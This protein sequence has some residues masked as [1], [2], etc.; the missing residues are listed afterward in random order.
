MERSADAHALVQFENLT[1]QRNVA[2]RKNP[3][4]EI[5]GRPSPSDTESSANSEYKD[6]PPRQSSSTSSSSSDPST[7]AEPNKL[8]FPNGSR[9]PWPENNDVD[10]HKNLP[11]EE[12]D[13]LNN[14]DYDYFHEDD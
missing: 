5:P 10:G 11:D 6:T 14:F 4:N 2:S 3:I 12:E 9:A 13:Q 1:D 7:D 8:L